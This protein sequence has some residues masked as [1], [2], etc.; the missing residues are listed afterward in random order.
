M[1]VSGVELTG[2]LSNNK[3]LILR[4]VV[5]LPAQG[6]LITLSSGGLE[7]SNVLHFWEVEDS[8]IEKV[9]K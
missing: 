6:R 8:K 7:P 2:Y 4:K 3:D 1:I 5:F 9:R